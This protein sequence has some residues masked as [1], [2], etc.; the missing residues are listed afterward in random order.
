MTHLRERQIRWNVISE[1]DF[2]TNHYFFWIINGNW[3]EI[4]RIK[5]N[6][7]LELQPVEAV[8][9][10]LERKKQRGVIPYELY[11]LD[12]P[13]HP[14]V[15]NWSKVYSGPVIKDKRLYQRK[16]VSG[17]QEYMDTQMKRASS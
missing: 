11:R 17:L 5:T 14:D 13:K 2:T 12:S 7:V 9:S 1:P 8:E 3:R 16:I 4:T 15:I 6:L 10:D